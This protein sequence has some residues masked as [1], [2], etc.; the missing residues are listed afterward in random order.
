LIRHLDLSLICVRAVADGDL[1]A[2]IP[3][4]GSA[5]ELGEL[6]QSINVMV[7]T[8]QARTRQQQATA[9]ALRNSQAEISDRLLRVQRQQAALAVIANHPTSVQGDFEAALPVITATVADALDVARVGIWL[10]SDDRTVL[11]C[12][13]M[14]ERTPSQ[15]AVGTMLRTDDYPAY[16]EAFLSGRVIDAHDARLD[17]RTQEFAV[18]YLQP[19]GI[20]ALLDAA[21]RLAGPVVG[22]VCHEHIG[23]ARTWQS[24]EVSF[25]GEVADQVAQVLA[26]SERRRAV[27]ELER[28]R[29]LLRDIIDSMPSLLVGVDAEGRVTQW[30]REAERLTGR[31]AAAVHGQPVMTMLP[32]LAPHLNQVSAAIRERRPY[33]AT[34]VA[35]DWAGQS[36]YADVTIYPLTGK[37]MQGAVIRLDDVTERVRIEEMIIQ[38]EK[39]LSVGG[40]AA[41][42]AHEINNPLAG[43]LQNAQ[44]VCQRLQVD[45]PKNRTVAAACGVNLESLAAYLQQRSIGPML[46]AIIASGQRAAR[47]VEN[48]LSFSRKSESRFTPQDLRGLLDRTVELAASDYD[49]KKK[50]DFR[51]ITIVREYAADVPP[52][53]CEAGKVQQV[54]LNIL[55]NGAEAM[56]ANRPLGRVPRFVLRV[57]PEGE[58]VRVE[59]E[60]NGPG[61]TEAV[62][63]RA[64]EPFFTTKGLGEG[65]GLGLSVS[66]F[67]ITENHGGTLAVSSVPEQGA[68]FIIR[69]PQRVRTG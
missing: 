18:G 16:F 52:V 62:R 42:M 37:G 4:S 23:S 3:V 2:R 26:N 6:Q 49:L 53:R 39:M 33:T 60:D 19:L 25:A 29:G 65:T 58:W 57:Q 50:Y 69:L 51:Q 56:T 41:G 63:K 27:E 9:N 43:I 14:F 67:I 38:S 8:I 1:S 61:M 47:I 68:N 59:I 24:D 10:L 15:S 44:V 12:V 17:P 48:I 31:Q 32:Q 21:I 40:L 30:N 66:Y 55:R 5:D 54:F 11:R 13:A 7:A 20:T 28:L 36:R 34:K 64:F 45:F 46:E 22:I 35:Q